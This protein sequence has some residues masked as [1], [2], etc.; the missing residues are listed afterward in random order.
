MRSLLIKDLVMFR[1]VLLADALATL[2]ISI[3]FRSPGVIAIVAI[4]FL[5]QS[6][7]IDARAHSDVLV[8]S[9]P[10]S[11]GAVVR[12]RYA[13]TMVVTLAMFFLAELVAAGLRSMR[14]T[15]FPAMSWAQLGS[16]ATVTLVW[17]A[18]ILP[19]Y[20]WLGSVFVRYLSFIVFVI[21]FGIGS[22]AGA[23]RALVSSES[24]GWIVHLWAWS[25]SLAAGEA[26]AWVYLLLTAA[27]LF[28]GSMLLSV[29]LYQRREF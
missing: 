15:E 21:A 16:V 29:R 19:L 24:T 5:T 3:L 28:V 22:A 18:I 7:Q 2:L 1:K 14:L 13:E 17:S 27:V 8:N 4:I 20:F 9:L 12:S 6:I 11:R 10:V 23:I 25:R 26:F